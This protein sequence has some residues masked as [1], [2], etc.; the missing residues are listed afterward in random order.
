MCQLLDGRVRVQ[1]SSA[2]RPGAVHG[3]A[4]L[5]VNFRCNVRQW[6]TRCE[7]PHLRVCLDRGCWRCLRRQVDGLLSLERLAAA[8]DIADGLR[9]PGRLF[10]K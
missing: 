3:Q 10:S 4:N 5:Q 9:T 1:P 2:A 7:R 8:E 6:S